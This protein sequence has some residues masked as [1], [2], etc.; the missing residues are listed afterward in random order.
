MHSAAQFMTSFLMMIIST[1]AYTTTYEVGP[2][3]TYNTPHALYLA[4]V[5]SA[6]DTI[7]IA[8]QDYSGID[9]LAAWKQD[10]LLIRGIGGRPHLIAD[11]QYIWGKGIWVLFGDNITVDNIEFSGAAVPD[12]NG[13]GIRLDGIGM[14]IRRCY[15]HDNENGIL[16]GNGGGE[17]SI[18]FSEFAYNGFG[19]G[20]SHNL[21]INNVDRF[22]F[23]YNYS[24]HAVV[25]H[26]LKS[27][28]AENI[29]EYNRIMDEDSGNSS[30]LIDLSNGG[31][32]TILGNLFMQGPIAT[33]RNLIGYGLE[34]LTKTVNELYVYN[35]TMVNK[36]ASCVFL[37]LASGTSRAEVINNIFAGTGTIISGSVD[38][39]TRN[40][41]S[42]TISDAGFTDEGSFDYQLTQNSPAIDYGTSSISP[43]PTKSYVHPVQSV[44]RAISNS[45]IDAGAYEYDQGIVENQPIKAEITVESGDIL[46]ED[47]KFGL[48]LKSPD[49]S[50]FRL[51]VN[52]SGGLSSVEISCQ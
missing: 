35:N 42:P 16:T 48:V 31:L 33:N 1:T 15:F 17:V 18:E 29:I 8:A 22:I 24:H 38:I 26:N 4:E 20:Q 13:A 12:K 40:Y 34:G 6:G 41:I 36:R 9:A 37:H 45:T 52:D 49:G 27:R 5:L 50:C 32:T 14:K 51:Q 21:Y 47:Q 46:V 23:R 44:N 2:N 28:A 19:D 30:R 7:N 25:G 11:G 43:L 3:Q 39:N 10:D